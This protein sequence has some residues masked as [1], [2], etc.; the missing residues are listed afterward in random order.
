MKTLIGLGCSHTQGSA[1]VK[2]FNRLDNVVMYIGSI[3]TR[4]DFDLLDNLST[5][6]ENYNFVFIGDVKKQSESNFSK[7]LIKKNIFHYKT[8]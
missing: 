4:L 7:I 2:N 8:N 5:N 3:D 6:L 1:Y